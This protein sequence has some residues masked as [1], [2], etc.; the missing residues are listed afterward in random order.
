MA[1]SQIKKRKDR[2]FWN[3][4]WLAM[5][6]SKTERQRR[7]ALI[8]KHPVKIKPPRRARLTQRMKTNG[9][10][11]VL[12]LIDQGPLKSDAEVIAGDIASPQ[13]VSLD[14]IEDADWPRLNDE[15]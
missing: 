12:A 5:A 13:A 4:I 10:R 2:R 3:W 7:V 11:R 8:Q 15:V 1:K 14:A 6:D 9:W